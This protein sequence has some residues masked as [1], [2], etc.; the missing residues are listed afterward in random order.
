MIE[1]WSASKTGIFPPCF[2]GYS[3][4]DSNATLRGF[5]EEVAFSTRAVT[6]RPL[7][8]V[9]YSLS[10]VGEVHSPIPLNPP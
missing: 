10:L 9:F 7:F 8:E 3:Q 4:A 5:W 6:L 2:T 1:G